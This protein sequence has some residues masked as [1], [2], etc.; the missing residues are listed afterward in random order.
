M[1]YHI[2]IDVGTSSAKTLV[3]NESGEIVYSIAPEYD[4]ATPR[5]GW[6]ECDPAHWWKAIVEALQSIFAQ[7]DITAGDIA[8]VGLTGQMHGLVMLNSAGEVLRPCIMWNDQR[9]AQQCAE[10]TEQVGPD[11]VLQLTGNPVLPGFTAPK[12]KW[13]QANEPEVFAQT[14]K[15]LLPKDYIRYRLSGEFFTDVSDAS[16][17]GL[18]DVAQRNWSDEMREACGVPRD[19]L[20]EVTES[21]VASTKV[22]AEAAKLTGLKEGTPI[23]AGGGDQA[24]QAVGC[25]IVREG[26]VSATF[27][28][29]GVVFA[30]A[31]EYLV[32]PH[33]RL[34]AFCHAVPGKWHLMGVML[35]A[36]GSF[37]WYRNALGQEEVAAAKAAGKDPYEVLSAAAEDA[38]AGCEGLLFLPYLSGE[39]T[40]HPDPHARGVFFGLSLRHQKKHLTRSVMEGITFGMRDSL[41]LMRDLGIAPT[42]VIASGGGAKSP[43]WRQMMAD[44]FGATITTN[45]ASEGAALGAAILAGVGSGAYESVEAACEQTLREIN[46]TEAGEHRAIYNDFYTHYA[47]LYPALKP[48]FAALAETVE[49]H[50]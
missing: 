40:P 38:P 26:V 28:T 27:G 22:S 19:W 24:A 16:G 49:K 12:I 9:T 7:T 3:I 4:F 17:M 33:G 2:G 46:R 10:L 37:Q 35:S 5:P 13:V 18:L 30:H 41:E 36:A 21:P 42:E 34:H 44:I 8:G 23:I 47:A 11:K 6:A 14:A 31:D 48:R 29:S 32:E 45:N 39:R 43:F 1:P 50:F 15:I 20:A 25:G